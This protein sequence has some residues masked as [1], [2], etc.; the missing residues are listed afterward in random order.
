MGHCKWHA[1]PIVY[2]SVHGKS[3]SLLF[4]EVF[5]MARPLSSILQG[6]NIDF[7]K[8]L[9]LLDAALDQ[10]SKLIGDT[11]NIIQAVEEN[12]D[13]IKWEE[14]DGCQVSFPR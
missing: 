2:K 10:L 1:R 3:L 4:R 12:F 11:Q 7:G 6:V 13:G 9:N 8:A 5:A 14:R